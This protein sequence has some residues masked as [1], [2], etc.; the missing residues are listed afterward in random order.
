MVLLRLRLLFSLMND[1]VDYILNSILSQ[2]LRSG[3]KSVQSNDNYYLSV[4]FKD[5]TNIIFWNTNKYYGWVSQGIVY[6]DNKIYS[7][8]DGRPKKSTM[9]KLIKALNNFKY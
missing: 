6:F 4:S 8:K 5:G 2:Q 7:W 1:G 3:I 9:Y